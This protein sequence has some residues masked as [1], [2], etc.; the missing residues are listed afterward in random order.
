MQ[1]LDGK[2]LYNPQQDQVL[3]IKTAKKIQPRVS[4][5]R[6]LSGSVGVLSLIGI[7]LVLI[8]AASS[9][10]YYLSNIIQE[11]LTRTIALHLEKE[12]LINEQLHAIHTR[13]ILIRD[14]LL[15]EDPFTKDDFMQLHSEYARRVLT[16]RRKLAELPLSA[17]EKALIERQWGDSQTGYD[18]HGTLIE[19]S[20]DSELETRL[21]LYQQLV[22]Q[23]QSEFIRRMEELSSYRSSLRS[24]SEQV[25]NEA[26]QN[27]FQRWIW[28][29][30]LYMLT[31]VGGA[32]AIFWFYLRQR[33]QQ[34]LLDWQATHDELTALPNRTEFKH[35]LQSC[36]DDQKNTGIKFSVLQLDI[37][38][39]K[40]INDT[41]G[42][43]V[44]DEFLK[45]VAGILADT[46][47]SGDLVARLGG[48]EFGILLH[49]CDQ[50]DACKI[51]K[52]ICHMLHQNTFKWGGE[53][54]NLT[55]S[56]GLLQA[57][58]G[59]T[60]P[61]IMKS[62]DIAC[63]TA[64]ENGGNCCHIFSSDDKLSEERR[65]ELEMAKHIRNALA[66]D[67]IEL[68]VQDIIPLREG[69]GP[70]REV[71]A[72]I[73]DSEQNPIPPG[74]FLPIAEKYN[75][76]SDIDI[77]VTKA[78][79]EY[80]MA[81][82]D[83]SMPFSINLSGA[84]LNS[85]QRLDHMVAL[86]NNSGVDPAL[87]IFEITE[88]MAITN[89][90]RAIEFMHEIKSLGCKFALDDFGSGLSSFTYLKQMPVDYLKIDGSFIQHLKPETIDFSFVQSIHTIAKTMEILV[91]A[92]WVEDQ[93]VQDYL[94]AIGV[95]FAQGFHIGHPTPL[96]P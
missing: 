31:L 91:V 70:F 23:T 12:A 63:Y 22:N 56:I 40:V 96:T 94:S 38:H 95:D 3:T 93:T 65:H 43:T 27:Q 47:R 10:T 20:L 1:V 2:W 85:E 51:A 48:D 35:Q 79:C 15:E 4:A 57:H 8:I 41:A 46:V 67:M 34:D 14:I 75:L 77:W 6:K 13:H 54:Y 24:I 39:F 32:M 89:L 82:N 69:L 21:Q 50:H 11:D 7:Y 28:L 80:I 58:E 66:T 81:S 37:D 64:K 44:G 52:N 62:A 25:L 83:N 72:R 29:L 26:K 90:T 59:I 71:L 49:G 78:V 53:S 92:E 17:E 87:L 84:T 55:T 19:K 76:V 73:S 61:A 45:Q 68:H 30:A 86:I 36:I 5:P 88:T 74:A 42:H 9:I 16:A 60:A 18:T 33:R